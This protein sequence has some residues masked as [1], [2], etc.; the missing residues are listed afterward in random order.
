MSISRLIIVRFLNRENVVKKNKDWLVELWIK[1]NEFLWQQ[2]RAIPFVEALVLAGAYT[3]KKDK[4]NS[5]AIA[6]LVAG[7]ILFVM[8]GLM[9]NRHGQHAKKFRDEA[10]EAIPNPGQ[11]FLCLRSDW[12]AASIPFLLAILNAGT[13][14]ILSAR[15]T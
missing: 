3:L 9:I 1:H 2:V 13:A 15:G 14:Y 7:A 5:L 12:I 10:G 6:I 8:I 11:P 4:E